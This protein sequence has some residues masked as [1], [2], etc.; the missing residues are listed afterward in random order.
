MSSSGDP[1]YESVARRATQTLW[2]LRGNQTGLLGNV[3]DVETLDWI[4]TMSG[5]GAGL[6]SFYEYLLKVYIIGVRL[7]P[8]SQL[9]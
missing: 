3:I 6:D 5:V 7:H 8:F 4:G 9:Y 1:I 2:G